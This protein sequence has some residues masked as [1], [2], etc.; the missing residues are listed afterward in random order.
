MPLRSGPTLV[1][2][3]LA[4][5]LTTASGCGD[6]ENEAVAETKSERPLKAR[7]GWD[8][9]GV[10]VR[11]GDDFRWTNCRMEIRS[12]GTGDPFHLRLGIL[13]PLS[14]NRYALVGFTSAG[15]LPYNPNLGVPTQVLISC[16][17]GIYFGRR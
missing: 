13:K 3:A 10:I 6:S 15:G 11:N 5:L 4:V 9:I 14:E 17:E 2:L 16:Q 1:R 7:L 12:R 8:G